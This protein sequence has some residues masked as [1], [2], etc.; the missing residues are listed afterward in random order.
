[1][2]DG[3]PRYEHDRFGWGSH[4]NNRYAK[5]FGER[6]LE[7]PSGV[8][9]Q[10]KAVLLIFEVGGGGG[11]T[12]SPSIVFSLKFSF[13]LLFRSITHFYNHFFLHIK[14]SSY[15]TLKTTCSSSVLKELSK[16]LIPAANHPGL[17]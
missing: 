16:T 14:H 15:S 9:M 4:L 13:C 2:Q 7:L 6:S 5:L 3:M 8:T 11:G 12:Q 10:N 17:E 1:M